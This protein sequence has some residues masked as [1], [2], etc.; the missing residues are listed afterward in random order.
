MASLEVQPGERL[1]SVTTGG[2]GYGDP[3][4]REPARVRD[5]VLEHRISRE[6]AREVYGVVLD[7]DAV[8]AAAT[9]EL[10]GSRSTPGERVAR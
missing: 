9:A 4:E 2:A 5:D 6:R 7:S 1:I 10:R 8:D 3:L